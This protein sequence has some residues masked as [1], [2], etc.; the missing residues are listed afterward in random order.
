MVPGPRD[1]VLT[2]P[3]FTGKVLHCQVLAH[4][5]EKARLNDPFAHGLNIGLR[6]DDKG[7]AKHQRQEQAPDP[8]QSESPGTVLAPDKTDCKPGDDEQQGHT[9]LARE[10]H[11]NIQEI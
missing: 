11:R 9:P 6:R 5:R 8:T 4:E 1:D 7:H 3:C 2:T 10:I